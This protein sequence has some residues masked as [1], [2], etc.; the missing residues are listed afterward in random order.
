[1]SHFKTIVALAWV[2]FAGIVIT[3]TALAQTDAGTEGMRMSTTQSGWHK[4]VLRS[5]SGSRQVSFTQPLPAPATPPPEAVEDSNTE[6]PQVPPAPKPSETVPAPAVTAAP[7]HNDYQP[8]PPTADPSALAYEEPYLEEDAYFEDGC[9][10]CGACCEAP[11]CGEFFWLRRFEFF[12]GAEGFKGPL[13]LGRNGNFGFHEGFNFGAPL[14]GPAGFGYQIGFQAVHSNF[15]GNQVIDSGVYDDSNRNQL[16]LTAGLFHRAHPC[17][18]L[19]SAVVFDW[20]HDEYYVDADLTQL[21]AELSYVFRGVREV[22]FWGAFSLEGDRMSDGVR[23]DFPVESTDIYA[24]F[25]RHHFSIGGSGRISSGATSNGDAYV[26]ADAVIPLGTNWAIEN[27][28]AMLVPTE[29]NPVGQ[30]EESWSV[31]VR[32]VWY[33]G[34]CARGALQDP[35]HPVLGVAD[36]SVFMIDRR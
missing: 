2:L 8:L 35:Y 3:G 26:G 33:P 11:G 31:G 20:L 14:G 16:F 9:G 12:V 30:A 17:G 4:R 25:Y 32:L 18:G 28:F 27:G 1:M 21:R 23:F 10:E 24:L 6:A 19:Q 13:D 36:N 22:G 29:S 34:R 15:E 5:Y 7:Q